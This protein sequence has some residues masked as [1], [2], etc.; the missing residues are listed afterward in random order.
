MKLVKLLDYVL[1][2]VLIV[3]ESVSGNPGNLVFS[4]WELFNGYILDVPEWLYSY[5]VVAFLA[6]EDVIKIYLVPDDV[7][8]S[9]LK[10][11]L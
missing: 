9:E 2:D 8:L 11:F 5:R 10:K 1:C 6:V 7:L 4:S 3:V